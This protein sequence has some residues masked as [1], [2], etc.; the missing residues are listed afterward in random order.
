MNYQTRDKY[1]SAITEAF[2]DYNPSVV[3]VYQA[4]DSSFIE[5]LVIADSFKDIFWMT[6]IKEGLKLISIA[7]G[8]DDA[9]CLVIGEFVTP[10]EFKERNE[11]WPE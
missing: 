11:Q 2:K 9:R 10:E 4:D 5:V 7:L 6:R 3:D 1:I 8:E